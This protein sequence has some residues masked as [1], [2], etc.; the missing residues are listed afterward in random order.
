METPSK[1]QAQY[2]EQL[3]TD[4]SGSLLSMPKNSLAK[5]TG[6]NKDAVAKPITVLTTSVYLPF[7]SI[8]HGSFIWVVIIIYGANNVLAQ[9]A[10]RYPLQGWIVSKDER[11]LS[12]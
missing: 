8:F 12:G 10:G 3:N 6:S 2:I 4:E 7:V 5:K 9:S 1:H 11:A